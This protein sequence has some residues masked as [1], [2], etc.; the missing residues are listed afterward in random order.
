MRGQ[1]G[2]GRPKLTDLDKLF[3]VVALRTRNYSMAELA[4]FMDVTPKTIY[5][6]WVKHV[7]PP[8]ALER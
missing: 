1:Y 4:R 7:A 5:N 3:V 2:T 8:Q 6:I